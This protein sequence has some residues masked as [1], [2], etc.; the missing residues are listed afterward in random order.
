MIHI[1][2]CRGDSF[3][4]ESTYF[5]EICYKAAGNDIKV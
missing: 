3:F 5:Y 2:M 1:K 4:G